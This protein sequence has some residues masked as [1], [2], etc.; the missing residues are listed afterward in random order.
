MWSNRQKFLV[1]LYAR[2]AG[3]AA[4]EYRAILHAATAAHSAA[5]RSLTQYHFDQAMA[6]LEA[7]LDYRIQEGFVPAPDPRRIR[8][9]GHWRRRLS[10]GAQVNARH[11][12]VLLDLWHQLSPHLTESQRSDAYLLAIAAK[13]CGAPVADLCALR[14]HQ[15]GIV[16]SALRD[17]LHYAIR[18]AAPPPQI[19]P[20]GAA[21][22]SEPSHA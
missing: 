16:C 7:V 10:S 11:L 2:A 20:Q 21:N 18:R 14:A 19:V 3:L 13:A 8:S 4:P 12:H 6:Q 1:H 22:P 9:L 5:D 17:R 15:A